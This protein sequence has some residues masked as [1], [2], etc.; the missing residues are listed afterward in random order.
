[1]SLSGASHSRGF[2]PNEPDPGKRHFV[3]GSTVKVAGS[4]D[5]SS[6]AA[7]CN[8]DTDNH[9]HAQLVALATVTLERRSKCGIL[10]CIVAR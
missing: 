8:R 4:R 3:T 7:N 6:W 1:M 9:D 10:I 2:A 5:N